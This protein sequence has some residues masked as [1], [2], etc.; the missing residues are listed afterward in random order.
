MKSIILF[1]LVIGLVL[2]SISYQKQL[3]NNTT[4]KIITE[5]R[6][7]PRSI[8]EEQLGQSNIE[9][10]FRDMFKNEDIFFYG[11]PSANKNIP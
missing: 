7:I 1:F 10:S 5:Y 2:M 6:F 3:I 9:S 8:Y 11:L 4:T